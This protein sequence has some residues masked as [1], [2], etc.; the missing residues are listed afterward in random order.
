M[1]PDARMSSDRGLAVRF[2]GECPGLALLLSL[3]DSV[4]GIESLERML[5]AYAVHRDGLDFERAHLLLYDELRDELVAWAGAAAA[6]DAPPVAEAVARAGLSPS[7][8]AP[9]PARQVKWPTQSLEGLAH[10]AW[11]AEPVAVH[12]PADA[13]TAEGALLLRSAERRHGLIVG[14][15]ERGGLED[16]RR[17]RLEDFHAI[18]NHVLTAFERRQETRRAQ[19][20]IEALAEMS[21]AAVSSLNVAEVLHLAAETVAREADVAGAAIWTAHGPESLKLKVTHGPEKLRERTARALQPLAVAAWSTLKPAW[22][23]DPRAVPELPAERA[24]ELSHIATLPLVAYGRAFGALAIYGLRDGR[25]L[26]RRKFDA[27][28]RRYLMALADN[29]ALALDQAERCAQLQRAAERERELRLRLQRFEQLAEFG[30]AALERER[31]LRNPVASIMAFARRAHAG[32]GDQDPRREYFEIVLREAERLES[33]LKGVEPPAEPKSPSLER[34]QPNELIQQVLQKLGERLV[35]RR[36]RLLKK[37]SPEVPQ[38]LLDGGRVREAVGNLLQ[39]A[40][41]AVSLGGR[42]KVESKKLGGHVVIEIAHDGA[43]EP[44]AALD[45]L[46]VPFAAPATPGRPSLAMVER[47]V[48]EHGGEIRTR[49]EGEWSSVIAFT[50]P[51]RENQDRRRANGDRRHSR[52]RRLRF[53]ESLSG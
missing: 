49:S 48:R 8:A 53:P 50:L 35:R 7:S 21:R 11:E 34:V 40:L 28:A 6:A 20:C 38:L 17:Q 39:H 19:A 10:L 37:L 41:D 24:D 16:Q 12:A 9:V 15:W 51:V 22:I 44:G 32:A 47:I 45:Q 13:T 25:P 33:M 52:D 36:I 3:A 42:L 30:V 5:L 18:A 31:A 46:F 43:R 23:E 1:E 29:L 14:G 4:A 27:A 2:A 26:D